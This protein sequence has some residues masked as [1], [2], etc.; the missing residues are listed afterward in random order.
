MG[1]EKIFAVCAPG[2][3]SFVRAELSGLGITPAP[4][5]AIPGGVEF[6]A[7]LERIYLANLWLRTASRITVRLG[8]FL[9][10]GFQ[11][12]IRKTR[13]LEWGRFLNPDV[14]VKLSVTC[15]SSRLYHSGA[16]AERIRT[17]IREKMG[18]VLFDDI[19]GIQADEADRDGVGEENREPSSNRA[20]QLVIVRIHK[21]I[22]TLS[23]DSSGD[24]LHK[25]GYRLETAK[26]PLRE[27]LAAA[28]IM[29]SGWDR[30]SALMDPFCGSGTIP[31]EAGM[32]A[33]NL[34]PG[35]KRDF[36]FMRWP[37]FDRALWDAMLRNSG[38]K[39]G[40]CPLMFGSDRDEGAVAIALRN[41]ARAGLSDFVRFERGAV[42]DFSPPEGSK[43]GWIVTNPP[44]GVRVSGGK[45]L[46]N[47]YARFGAVVREKFSGWRCAVITA[48]RSLAGHTKLGFD[49]TPVFES[50][51]GGLKVRCHAT[52]APVGGRA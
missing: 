42:S 21:D 4:G 22:C 45:D 1:L 18:T 50:N 2:L 20:V 12:L 36:A 9:A 23:I 33:R 24:L 19:P 6:E 31:I 47:L 44:Y 40:D 11:E 28:V 38:E 27:T 52:A 15:R 34:P 8:E 37:G 14:A 13:N 7:G 25:R 35:R 49:K 41:A 43:P 16:V 5:P 29:A 46:R 10:V 48:D 17:A 3:E 39:T 51:N 30:K 32:M 26:A